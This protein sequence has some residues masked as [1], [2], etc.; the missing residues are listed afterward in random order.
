MGAGAKTTNN[1]KEEL[2]TT[3]ELTSFGEY[4]LSAQRLETLF[5]GTDPAGV[6]H[7][8][9]ENWKAKVGGAGVEMGGESNTTGFNSKTGSIADLY[10]AYLYAGE[11]E[12]KFKRLAHEPGVEFYNHIKT[13]VVNEMNRRLK[14]AFAQWLQIIQPDL[15]AWQQSK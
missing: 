12:E 2:F 7:S 1:M 3:T 9:I 15:S 6:Y 11:G 8:D 14:A 4:L 5:P 10:A 13:V